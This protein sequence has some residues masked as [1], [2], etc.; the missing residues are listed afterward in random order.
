ME[1]AKWKQNPGADLLGKTGQKEQ[2]EGHSQKR[3]WGS[4]I[5]FSEGG[6]EVILGT[7]RDLEVS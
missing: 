3:L 2:R 4:L 1:E 7:G 5:L 6:S